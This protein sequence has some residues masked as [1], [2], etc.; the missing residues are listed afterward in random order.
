MFSYRNKRNKNVRN[1]QNY[2][3][4]PRVPFQ[5]PGTPLN[6]R[7]RSQKPPGAPFPGGNRNQNCADPKDEYW[8]RRRHT[9]NDSFP[10]LKELVAAGVN[11]SLVYNDPALAADYMRQRYNNPPTQRQKPQAHPKQRVDHQ[12]RKPD[13]RD[14]VFSD[15]TRNMPSQHQNGYNTNKMHQKPSQ[16][17]YQSQPRISQ[18]KPRQYQT[19]NPPTNAQ[20]KQAQSFQNAY[21]MAAPSPMVPVP[22]PSGSR[23]RRQP[24]A[25]REPDTRHR[26]ISNMGN[27]RPQMPISQRSNQY[28]PPGTPFSTAPRNNYQPP[29]VPQKTYQPPPVPQKTYQ[30]QVQQNQFQPQRYQN[31][32]QRTQKS[33]NRQQQP[34]S[35]RS[36][37]QQPP[38]V[39]YKRVQQPTQN[40]NGFKIPQHQFKGP[41]GGVFVAPTGS[42]QP[43]NHNPQTN[44]S[45]QHKHKPQNTQRAPP[46][47]VEYDELAVLMSGARKKK[48][49]PQQQNNEMP[50]IPPP[51][52]HSKKFQR[53]DY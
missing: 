33:N 47:G 6:G 18:Q 7:V 15:R 45:R 40:G 46:Q 25:S 31:P 5:P 2:P 38:P 51:K 9:R 28:Q 1:Q 42:T 41:P 11:E 53:D 39:A 30:P 44:H 10:E 48:F 4:G 13:Q 34:V 3:G 12:K 24:R 50:P 16:P 22:Q 26:V 23:H 29:T 17:P 27:E 43:R 8:L 49:Q 52:I 19:N 20:Q 14:H 35:Q 36:N 32:S 37:Q 21:G